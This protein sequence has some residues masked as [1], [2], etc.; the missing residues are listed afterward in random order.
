MTGSTLEEVAGIPESALSALPETPV[1]GVFT[2][3]TSGGTR[4]LVLFSRGNITQ[5]QTAIM[6]L[7]D[8]NRVDEIYCY[9]QPYHVFG[10]A[11]GFGLAALRGIK[12]VTSSGPYGRAAHAAWYERRTAR[13]LTLATPAQMIDLCATIEALQ[14]QPRPTYSCILGGAAVARV[15]WERACAV[16]RIAEPSIGYGC[17]EASP[18]VMHLPPGVLPVDDGEVG[19][20]LPHMRLA[21]HREGYQISGPGVAMAT[22]EKGV[23]TLTDGRHQVRDLLRRAPDGRYVFAHRTDMVLNRGGEKFPLE[24]IEALL[25]SRL[26]MDT[27]CVSLPDARLGEELGILALAAPRLDPKVVQDTLAEAYQRAFDGAKMVAVT[28][29]PLDRNA[30]PDRASARHFLLPQVATQ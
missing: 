23:L 14:W 20:P 26:G 4:K 30:K 15:V 28:E 19:W 12:I 7:F 2:T 13:L 17:T 25:R 24:Q 16:A 11:L 29:L 21:F 5:S 18:G 27:I 22:V 6:D 1:L 3:G 10:L 9:P 8:A